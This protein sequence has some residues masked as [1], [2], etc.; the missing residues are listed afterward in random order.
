MN[1]L[2]FRE[3]VATT[4]ERLGQ[5]PEVVTVVLQHYFKEVRAALTSLA[6]PRV[7]VLNLGTF[8]VKPFTV[9][10]KLEARLA[11][12]DKFSAGQYP[13]RRQELL[14]EIR[15]IEQVLQLVQ[16]EKERKQTIKKGPYE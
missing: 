4:A 11:Q 9:K 16:T 6:H 10:K 2:K 12:L 8:R 3:V 7:Q 14:E 13:L 1:P 15:A 5:R